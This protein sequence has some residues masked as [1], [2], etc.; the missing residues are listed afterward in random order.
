MSRL[1]DNSL[2]ADR[3][4]G[5][6]F[7][8]RLRTAAEVALNGGTVHGAPVFSGG[9]M[10]CDGANDYIVYA[11]DGHEFYSDEI[12]LEQ[13]F[14]P[15]FAADENALRVLFYD[16]G[17]KYAC[18]KQNNASNNNILFTLGGVHRSILYAD[19]LPHWKVNQRNVIQFSSDGANTNVRLN[20]NLV[21]SAAHIWTKQKITL[22][23]IGATHT[24]ASKFRGKIGSV[25]V[26]QSVLRERDHCNTY[27]NKSYGFTNDAVFYLPMTTA[28][29]EA[30]RTLDV[31]G[32]N[33]HAVF[34]AGGAI[35]TKLAKRGYGF[36]GGDHMIAPATGIFNRP[37]VGIVFEFTPHFATGIDSE[38]TFFSSSNLGR[39]EILKTNNAGGNALY[40]FLGNTIISAI[41]E[42][43][44]SPYWEEGGRNVIAISSDGSFTD[45]HLNEGLIL[46]A[47]ATAWTAKDPASFYFGCR[48]NLTRLF[49]GDIHSMMIFPHLLTPR[50]HMDLVWNRTNSIGQV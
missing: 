31:S 45:V 15:D 50:M 17:A 43:T 41:P 12:S 4:V 35:P 3:M 30:T 13:E 48:Y 11:L 6:T 49:L 24:G 36:D 10:I 38:H 34:G 7:A 1:H 18:Y 22:L 27:Y 21:F 20:N 14:W 16:S 28:C 42:V 2:P 44:Y 8:E 46:D 29:H 39:Y 25:K 26:Y 5:C 47:N 9:G 32:N 19:Y 23:G 33:N 40:I 37:E